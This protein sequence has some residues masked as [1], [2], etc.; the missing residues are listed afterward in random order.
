MSVII[1]NQN[2]GQNLRGAVPINRDI[3][4]SLKVYQEIYQ[5][6]TGRT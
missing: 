2:D 1:D 3:D 4:K 6:I 5:H